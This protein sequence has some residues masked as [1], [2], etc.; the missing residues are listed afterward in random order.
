[1]TASLRTRLGAFGAWLHPGY[2]DTARTEFAVEAEQLG[3]PVVWLG[4]GT[5]SIEDLTPVEQILEATTSV[6]VATAIVN[7]W[8]NDAAAIA[9][10]YRRLNSTYGDRFL[11]GVGIGH[12]E[13]VAT[14]RTPYAAM[15]DYLDRLD[16][17]GVPVDG[18]ILAALG[19]RALRLAANRTLGTHP[20]LVVPDHTREAR[21]MLGPGVVIAPEQTVVLDPDPLAARK[22]A[23]AFVSEPYLKLSNYTNNLRRYGYTDADLDD[24]GSDRLIDALVPHGSTEAVAS[25]LRD[26]LVAGAD[27]VGIQILTADGESPMPGYRALASTLFGS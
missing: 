11:L 10:A 23:R 6:V 8:T 5:A 21:G 15:V 13:A 25:R 26:H 9:K 20:Y 16:A 18:R 27:H 22:I 12:P 7:M 24:E 4:L 17:G 3:Y 14:Y 1:M 2:G 19:P